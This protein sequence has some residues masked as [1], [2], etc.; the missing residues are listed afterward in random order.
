MR[1]HSFTEKLSS[2]PYFAN[3]YCSFRALRYWPFTSRQYQSRHARCQLCRTVIY[4][5]LRN[6]SAEAIEYILFVYLSLW[7]KRWLAYECKKRPH[8]PNR[9]LLGQQSGLSLKSFF[10]PKIPDSIKI[11]VTLLIGGGK[12]QNSC[13]NLK[14]LTVLVVLCIMLKSKKSLFLLLWA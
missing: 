14:P 5:Q 4:E 10:H 9:I 12:P 13:F 7:T 2:G 1:S 8:V 6:R 11:P 3:L